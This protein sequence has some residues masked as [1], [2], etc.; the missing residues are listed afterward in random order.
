MFIAIINKYFEVVHAETRAA[1]GWKHGMTDLSFDLI[2]VRVHTAT[3]L[4]QHDPRCAKGTHILRTPLLSLRRR[5]G[6][7]RGITAQAGVRSC[8]SSYA[9]SAGGRS[10]DAY[11]HRNSW[12]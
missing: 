12:R 1:E 8:G 5:C 11:V 4:P 3:L 10:C 6:G 9:A 2:K 7:W